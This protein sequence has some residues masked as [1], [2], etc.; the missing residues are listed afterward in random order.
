VPEVKAGHQS[1][2][3]QHAVNGTANINYIN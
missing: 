1:V 2:V 3:E